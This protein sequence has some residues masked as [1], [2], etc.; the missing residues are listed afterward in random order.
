[1]SHTLCHKTVWH[2]CNWRCAS[3]KIEVYEMNV[4]EKKS[5]QQSSAITSILLLIYCKGTCV[6]ANKEW[7]CQENTFQISDIRNILH[8]ATGSTDAALGGKNLSIILRT[9]RKKTFQKSSFRTRSWNTSLST[10]WNPIQI[11]LIGVKMMT[12]TSY[13][14]SKYIKL[15]SLTP[16]CS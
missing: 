10:W 16:W 12:M 11:L 15:L 8:Q 5:R 1:M 2:F 14:R 7:C 13:K 6:G 4:P 9:G 3:L